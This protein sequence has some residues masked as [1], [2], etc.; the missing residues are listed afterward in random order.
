M[1][2]MVIWAMEEFQPTVISY[3]VGASVSGTYLFI[4]ATDFTRLVKHHFGTDEAYAEFQSELASRLQ[5]PI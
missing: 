2:P 1:G 4:E 3:L 5:R